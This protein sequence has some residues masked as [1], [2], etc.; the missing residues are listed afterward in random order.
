MNSSYG[1]LDELKALVNAAHEKGM[2]V[3]FDWVANHTSWDNV[4]ISE[5]PEWYEHKTSFQ[6]PVSGKSGVPTS[7]KF[8]A[9]QFQVWE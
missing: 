6:E 9:Y 4:W 2:K 7:Q 8:G 5:H 1:T 3:M